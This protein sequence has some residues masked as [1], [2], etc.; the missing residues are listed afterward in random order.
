M[1]KAG[2]MTKAGFVRIREAKSSGEW[3]K[4]PASARYK[5]KLMIP[6]YLKEALAVNEKA[7]DNFDRLAESYRRNFVGWIDSGK[8]E[9]TR[10]KRL[11]EAMQLLERNQKLGMK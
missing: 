11:A 4:T 1:M 8:K 9:E 6:S 7:S 2:K 5:K 10:R 3:F